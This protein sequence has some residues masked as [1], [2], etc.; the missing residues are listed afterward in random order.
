MIMDEHERR[1]LEFLTYV[2]FIKDEKVKIQIFFSGIP[3]LYS[4]KI[5]FD[6]PGTLEEALRKEKYLY[7]QNKGKPSFKKS[8]G[9]KK[10]SKMDQRKKG[11][12][13]QLFRTSSQGH[14]TQ[15]ESR[16]TN[17]SGKRPRQQPIK[18]LG[19]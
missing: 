1:F 8:W 9:G 11:Y 15:S 3:S 19:L 2:G 7:E 12:K 18:M 6:E 14:L 16:I 5:H 4:D 17:Y 13:P 10:K